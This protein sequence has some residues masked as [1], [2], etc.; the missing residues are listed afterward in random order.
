VCVSYLSESEGII[1]ASK[2]IKEDREGC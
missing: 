2:L 1:C